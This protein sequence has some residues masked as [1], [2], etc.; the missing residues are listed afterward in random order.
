[1]TRQ[2]CVCRREPSDGAPVRFPLLKTAYPLGSECRASWRVHAQS[3]REFINNPA[4]AQV[5]FRRWMATRE[6]VTA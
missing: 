5:A 1:M 4:K 2:C 6:K 3:L